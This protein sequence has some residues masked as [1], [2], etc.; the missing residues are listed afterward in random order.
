M[1]S[2]AHSQLSPYLEK[3]DTL[4]MSKPRSKH[5]AGKPWAAPGHTDPEQSSPWEPSSTK[6]HR[7]QLGDQP[8]HPRSLPGLRYRFTSTERGW[9]DADIHHV[10]SDETPQS[11]LHAATTARISLPPKSFLSLLLLPQ[12]NTPCSRGG[13]QGHRRVL[14]QPEHPWE[15]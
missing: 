12:Q 9:R 2:L 8:L 10:P 4:E 5:L 1:G 7:L 6:P 11:L 3:P 13:A 14:L 15:L